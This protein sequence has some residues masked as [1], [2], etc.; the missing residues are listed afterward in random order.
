MSRFW[1]KL[2]LGWVVRFTLESVL[3][4]SILS[5]TATAFIYVAKGM[6]SIDKDVIKAL[7]DLFKFWFVIFWSLTLLISLFRAIKHLFNHCHNGYV[8]KLLT[9]NQAEVIETIGYGDISKVFRKWMMAMIWSVSALMILSFAVSY[10]FLDSYQ[11]YNIYVL[12][13]FIVISGGLTI[14]LMGSRCKRV[15]LSKC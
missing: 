12:Y 11:W 10:L 5:F 14:P 3:L 8:L 15:K 6:I 7:F 4:A 2:W 13:I 9:C 1:F